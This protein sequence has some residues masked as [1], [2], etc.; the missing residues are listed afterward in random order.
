MHSYNILYSSSRLVCCPRVIDLCWMPGYLNTAVLFF[1]RFNYKTACKHAKPFFQ[2]LV[3]N[4]VKSTVQKI[5]ILKQ[6]RNVVVVIVYLRITAV[7]H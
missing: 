7:L 2:L 1:V 6:Q 3:Q 5:D 4:N